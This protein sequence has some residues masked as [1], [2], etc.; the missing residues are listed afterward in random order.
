MD[1]FIYVFC[2]IANKTRKYINTIEFYD[3]NKKQNWTLIE[4][5]NKIFKERQ[6]AGAMQKD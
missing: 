2:G 3:H 5:N 1:R 6:G 4:L